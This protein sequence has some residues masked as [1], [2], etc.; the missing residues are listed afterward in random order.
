MA[1]LTSRPCSQ[2]GHISPGGFL[3]RHRLSWARAPNSRSGGL[4]PSQCLSQCLE[5]FIPLPCIP[6]HSPL[7]QL[8][9]LPFSHAHSFH[10]D[11][12][13][14]QAVTHWKIFFP[15]PQISKLIPNYLA[16]LSI[17]SK[18]PQHLGVSGFGILIQAYLEKTLK[19]HCILL[20]PANEAESC[21]VLLYE[22]TI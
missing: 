6:L 7:S 9:M 14:M 5:N 11:I 4:C 21:S 8:V 2:S 13:I 16:N 10:A 20:H 12:T 17:R 22:C 15:P 1:L 19:G 18:C 3:L